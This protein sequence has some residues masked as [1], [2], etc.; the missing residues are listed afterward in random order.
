MDDEIPAYLTIDPTPTWD[1]D[2]EVN[3]CHDCCR[4]FLGGG[5][6][7]G[8]R[9]PRCMGHRTTW[10]RLGFPRRGVT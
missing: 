9:C 4:I 5:G 2:G 8:A 1:L 3:K 10:A 6:R 7:V